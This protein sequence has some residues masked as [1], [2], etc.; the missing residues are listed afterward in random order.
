M[1]VL[2]KWIPKKPI[3]AIYYDGEKSVIISNVLV[4]TENK[5]ESFIGTYYSKEIVSTDYRP[6][7]N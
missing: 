5:E 1:V 7:V 6:V 2:E 4:E 3:S